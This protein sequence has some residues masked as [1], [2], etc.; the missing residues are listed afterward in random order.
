[1]RLATRRHG[2]AV[3]YACNLSPCRQQ[4]QLIRRDLSRIGIDVETKEFPF[5]VVIERALRPHEPW[6]ITISDWGADYAD[7]SDFLNVLLDPSGNFFHFRSE[8]VTRL[9]DRAAAFSGP[10][11]YDT[12]GKL[13]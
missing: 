4:A 6:D 3:L 12:Y 5:D 2:T 11:R 1:R 13:A 9:L 8:R 7:P 10:A